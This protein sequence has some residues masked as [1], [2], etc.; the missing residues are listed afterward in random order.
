MYN[1]VT[2][3]DLTAGTSLV[4]RIPEE[5]VDTK[6]L[7]TIQA[8]LPEFVV[9]F[10]FKNVDG[11]VELTYQPGTRGKLQYFY[12]Q[13]TIREYTE[14]WEGILNPL[15]E[16]DDCFMTPFS[17]AL[18][19]EYI[20]YDKNTNKISLV[21]IPS[22]KDISDSDALRQMAVDIAT[23]FDISDATLKNRVLTS[24]LQGFNPKEFL[25]ML[26]YYQKASSPAVASEPPGVFA[27]SKKQVIE[28]AEPEQY[29]K[30]E[31]AKA[32]AFEPE[33]KPDM[34]VASARPGDIFI[35]RSGKGGKAKVAAEKKPLFGG[36][37]SEPKPVA[38]PK[39]AKP[40]GGLFG[41]KKKETVAPI[42][43]GAAANP[44][45]IPAN[46]VGF[47]RKVPAGAPVVFEPEFKDGATQIDEDISVQEAGLRLVSNSDLPRRIPVVIEIGKMFSI[48]RFDAVVGARQSDF[49]FN[50]NTKAISR[51]HAIIERRADGYC[52]IDIGS[53]AGTFVNGKKIIINTPNPIVSGD[54]ISIGNAGADYI[55]ED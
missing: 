48:G 37:K 20:Y 6:A 47:E 11:Q 16:C 49:E 7:Y 26:K 5:D 13:R 50:K 27:V 14:L 29:P 42:I 28:K 22:K 10:W 30:I 36:K 43:I 19:S 31:F 38:E 53:S 12:G 34:Q 17:F 15:L 46:P 45:S 35:D 1:I 52:I 40:K 24:I 2:K 33:K 18:N 32:P 39:Q 51:R 8:V 55:W 44:P 4:V 9:P 25:Q 41:S 23:N 21:Y 3:N 54:S